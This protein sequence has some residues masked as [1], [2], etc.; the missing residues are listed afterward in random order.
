MSNNR[1]CRNP[2]LL[3]WALLIAVPAGAGSPA[4][5]VQESLRRPTP[6]PVQTAAP[7]TP[8]PPA[9]AAPDAIRD[10]GTVVVSRFQFS[11]NTRLS[12]AELQ[13]VVAGFLGRPLGFEEIY[14]AADAVTAAYKARGFGLAT[15]V[16][17]AQ[18]IDGGIVRLEVIEGLIAAVG[19]EG[20]RDYRAGVLKAFTREVR[21]GQVYESAVVEEAVLRLND[22]PGLEARVVVEPG[23]AYGSS[24]LSFRLHEVPATYTVTVD[25]HGREALGQNRV[26]FDATWNNLTGGA[27]DLRLALVH[28]EDAL[29]DYLGL[30]YSMPLGA[31]GKRLAFALN[32]A[33]YSLADDGFLAAG[34]SGDNL[35]LRADY[36]QPLLRSRD[37]NLVLQAALAY[38]ESETLLGGSGSPLASTDLA[39]LELG[40]FWNRVF[41]NR[42]SLSV[43][44]RYA[45]NFIGQDAPLSDPD[46]I[47]SSAMQGKLMFDASFGW[48][49]APG[50]SLVT[51]LDGAYSAEPLPD[52]QKFSVGGPY[53]LRGYDSAAAR[54]DYGHHVALELQR[55]LRAF[56]TS[57]ILHAFVETA[58]VGTREYEIGAFTVPGTHT[59]LRSAGLGI[60][61][62]PQG[63]YGGALFFAQP[64]DDLELPGEDGRV[65]ASVSA[66]F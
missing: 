31:Q 8:T 30:T 19:F 37:Q 41:G 15:A 5:V 33:D 3:A 48:P 24:D 28:S 27:D 22:L 36:T 14:S 16:V 64:I 54:G 59:A 65:W 20:N 6:P 17:P 38:A 43:D 63:R 46:G 34:I 53:A 25:D 45:G 40:V 32:Y 12:E 23:A 21:S 56:G 58:A 11:G 42:S 10:A 66:R 57:H 26:L 55:S 4:G 9:A 35:N 1:L 7:A 51:R 50:W 60:T 47:D 52:L 18:R 29:L 62:N 39:W 44:A 2:L 13:T 49:F 61:I